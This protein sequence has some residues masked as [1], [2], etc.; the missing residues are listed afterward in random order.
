MAIHFEHT[1]DVPTEPARA[2]ALLDDVSQTPKWLKRCTGIEKVSDGPLAV[3]SK[4][5]YSYKDRGREGV[6]DGEITV[7]NPDEQL[8]YR[9]AD[10]MMDVR[11]D[12]R[13][14]NAD[15]GTRLTHAIDITPKTFIAKLFSPLIRRG[16]PK[17]TITAMETLRDLLKS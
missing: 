11:V 2:F 4:L 14:A 3:G 10:K 7:R 16:L 5:R 12:F 17:Q 9:Y 8:T 15:G 13:I 6:M 1:L